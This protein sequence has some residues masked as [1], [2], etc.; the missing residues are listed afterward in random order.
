MKRHRTILVLCALLAG[1]ATGYQKQT[2]FTVTGGFKEKDLGKNVYRVSFG[3]NGYT[4]A[5]T[6]Q[7]FWLYRCAELTLEKGF[8]GFEIL[9]DIRLAQSLSPE[10]VF[11]VEASEVQPAVFVP[12][13]IPTDEGNKPHIEADILLLKSPIKAHPPK[14]FDARKLKNALAPHVQEPMKSRGNVKPHIH[15]YLFPDRKLGRSA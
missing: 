1:C 2:Y 11:G 15:D 6:T 9:S 8:D 13:Y 7:C 5:E 14:V 10:K 4:T 3:A 12:I